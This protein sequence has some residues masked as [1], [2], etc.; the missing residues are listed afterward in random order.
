MSIVLTYLNLC[1]IFLWSW[2]NCNSGLLIRLRGYWRL[3]LLCDPGRGYSLNSDLSH[4]EAADSVTQ[5]RQ[6]NI[7]YRKWFISK[8]LD[9]VIWHWPRELSIPSPK[10]GPLRPKPNP[11]PVQ[12]QNPSPIGTGADSIITWATTHPTPPPHHPT[13]KHEG[14]L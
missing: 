10:T 9:W 12:N 11:K 8:A 5:S 2:L 7:I 3:A 1:F 14:V 6:H 13:F 4:S